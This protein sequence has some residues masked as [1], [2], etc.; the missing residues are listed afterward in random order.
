[1]AETLNEKLARI[2]KHEDFMV[3][4]FAAFIKPKAE[5]F[6]GDLVLYG[7]ANRSLS[8]SSGF[9]AMIEARNFTCAAPLLRMQ[10]DTAIRMFSA[11]LVKDP[12]HYAHSIFE[13]KPVNKY[14]DRSGEKLTDSYMARQLSQIHPWVL[15]VYQETSEL[16]HLSSRHIF[17]N[18]GK[19]NEEERSFNLAIG[20]GDADRRDEEY[21]EVVHAFHEVSGLVA[22][23]AAEWHSAIHPNRQY[24]VDRERPDVP[25][26]PSPAA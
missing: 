18:M 15:S 10:L 5:F 8:L 26:T 9:R 20:V 12:A 21:F 22:Q 11:R 24:R 23:F 13:G 3:E 4:M 19:L 16:V 1:M 7:I 14:K 6:T 25:P 17:L 2:K